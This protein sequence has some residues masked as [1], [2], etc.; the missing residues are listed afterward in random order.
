MNNAEISVASPSALLAAIP[1]VLGFVAEKSLIV[2]TLERNRM[3][4]V[5]RVDLA[6]D[7]LASAA[8]ISET[9]ASAGA[10]AAILVVVDNDEARCPMCHQDHRTLGET[11][12]A[13]LAARGI[14]VTALYAAEALS[15]GAHWVCLDGVGRGTHGEVDDPGSSPMAVAAVLAGRR[16]YGRR[17]EL[18]DVIAVN[19]P[20]RAAGLAGLIDDI[21]SRGHDPRDPW[22]AAAGMDAEA[23]AALV[24]GGGADLSDTQIAE[25]AVSLTDGTVRD[26]LYRLS[27][28]PAAANAEDAFTRLSRILPDPW[29]AEALVMVAWFAYSARGDGPLAGLAVEA[30]LGINHTH[31][32]AN[33]L[34]AALQAGVHPTRIRELT[35]KPFRRAGTGE[36]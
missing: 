6:D 33:L 36:Q 8:K 31:R 12:T 5:L 3:H 13:A 17:E 4:A 10:D 23:A 29:R 28:G 32:M 9:A 22:G 2:V 24:A 14:T 26:A 16:L 1:A 25:L 35:E 11:L 30:A 34:H 18:L 27:G 21:I 15:A 7:L 20:A 19:D